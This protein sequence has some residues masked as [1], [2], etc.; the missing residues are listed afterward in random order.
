M[1]FTHFLIFNQISGSLKPFPK[2]I[3]VEND[4]KNFSAPSRA[5]EDAFFDLFF[6]DL[7]QLFLTLMKH[8]LSYSGHTLIIWN[9]TV[10]KS[11]ADLDVG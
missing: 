10:E 4:P 11:R 6:V 7:E 1:I 5:L 3:G 2:K 9:C 8:L